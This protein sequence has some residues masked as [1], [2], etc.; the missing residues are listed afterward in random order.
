MADVA[1]GYQRALFQRGT[2]LEGGKL[3]SVV[4]TGNIWAR[5]GLFIVCALVLLWVAQRIFA[6]AQGNFAQEL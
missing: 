1:M 6:R 2:E 3:A 5:E 4:Y